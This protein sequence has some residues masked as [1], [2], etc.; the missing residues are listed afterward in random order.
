MDADHS[1]IC[2]YDREDSD[3]YE[4]VIENI[5]RLVDEAIKSSK[6]ELETDAATGG[7]LAL[8]TQEYGMLW[9]LT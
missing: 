9:T 1:D 3:E 7:T 4:W 5:K 8:T 6:D 2:R